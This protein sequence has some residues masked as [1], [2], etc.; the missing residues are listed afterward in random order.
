MLSEGQTLASSFC[1]ETART[2]PRSRRLNAVACIPRCASPAGRTLANHNSGKSVI[3]NSA[4]RGTVSKTRVAPQP[5]RIPSPII[6]RKSRDSA[7]ALAAVA[8]SQE[9]RC[10]QGRGT[11]ADDSER[12]GRNGARSTP[13]ASNLSRLG[14]S[15]VSRLVSKRVLGRDAGPAGQVCRP[16]PAKRHVAY[17]VSLPADAATRLVN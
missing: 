3:R 13:C 14:A 7:M 9:R 1:E 6:L 10:D 11:V 8:R 5:R 17:L 16:R 15:A 2:M 12:S 4:G